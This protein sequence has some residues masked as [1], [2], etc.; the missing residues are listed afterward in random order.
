MLKNLTIFLIISMFLVSCAQKEDTQDAPENS[1]NTE[2]GNPFNPENP[3]SC[4]AL[5]TDGDG[6]LDCQDPDIDNDGFLNE[7]DAFPKDKY[8]WLDSDGD[9]VGDNTDW[10]PE[11]PREQADFDGDTIGDNYDDDDDNDGVPDQFESIGFKNDTEE[12]F[13][14]DRDTLGD[15]VHD[16]DID[17][18]G[19]PNVFDDLFWNKNG[20][21]DIDGDL[22]PNESD[23]DIDGDLVPNLQDVFPYDKTE[24]ADDDLDILG[25]NIDP[26]D[27]ND[28][29]P[30]SW[31]EFPS[32]KLAI[33][34]S[35]GDGY[36]NIE[37]AFPFN[38]NEWLDSDGDGVGDNSD[39]FPLNPLESKDTDGDGIGDNTDSDIDND[40]FVNCIPLDLSSSLDC[41]RD[42][43]PEDR[44][45][46]DDTDG[47]GIGDNADEDDD[48]DMVPDVFD[49]DSLDGT[50]FSDYDKDR[51]PDSLFPISPEEKLFLG[52][53]SNEVFFRLDADMDNDG[54]PNIFDDLN[55][56]AFEYFD[57]DG[58]NIGHK[59]DLD[60]DGDGVLD[61]LDRFKYDPLEWSDYDN[62]LIGDN[63]D[64]DDDNDGTPDFWDSLPKNNRGFSDINGDNVP[65][66]TSN[67]LDG[68]GRFNGSFSCSPSNGIWRRNFLDLDED[69][70]QDSFCE[71]NEEILTS[72]KI[73]NSNSSN[74]S[75]LDVATTF[76]EEQLCFSERDT[77]DKLYRSCIEDNVPPSAGC[78]DPNTF[79]INDVCVAS[80][81]T[82][83]ANIIL[84]AESSCNS[85]SVQKCKYEDYSTNGSTGRNDLYPWDSEEWQ[86]IDGD[87]LPDNLTDFDIDNDGVPD[88]W[89]DFPSDNVRD[90]K[91]RYFDIDGDSFA[92]M[93]YYYD[94]QDNI[95]K[96]EY[97]SL[98]RS[99][100]IVDS[101]SD[102]DFVDQGVLTC[103]RVSDGLIVGPSHNPLTLEDI[104]PVAPCQAGEIYNENTMSCEPDPTF[105]PIIVVDGSVDVINCF[106]QKEEGLDYF[107]FNENEDSD[108][109]SDRI[110]D[111]NDNDI[112]GDRQDNCFGGLYKTRF[113]SPSFAGSNLNQLIDLEDFVSKRVGNIVYRYEKKSC[114]DDDLPFVSRTNLFNDATFIPADAPVGFGEIDYCGFSDCYY[115]NYDRDNDGL[116]DYEE[117]V[118]GS[119]PELAD[120]DGDL[121][122]D[123]YER[124]EGTDPLDSNSFLDTDKDGIPN[125]IDPF[126]KG[127]FDKESLLDQLSKSSSCK[128]KESKELCEPVG[129][130]VPFCSWVDDESKL[131]VDESNPNE[132][133]FGKKCI[134]QEIL[135]TKDIVLDD[136]L[137]IS[138]QIKLSS[139]NGSKIIAKN[140]ENSV[141]CDSDNII[142]INAIENSELLLDNIIIETN[143]VDIVISS[144]GTSLELDKSSISSNN[145]DMTT[146]I[147][148]QNNE[149]LFRVNNSTLRSIM[150]EGIKPE[151][152]VQNSMINVL[153]KDM[154]IGSTLLDC[155]YNDHGLEEIVLNSSNYYLDNFICIQTS[156]EDTVFEKNI[157]TLM[158]LETDTGSVV[159]GAKAMVHN[160]IIQTN[161][162]DINTIKSG[163]Q[164]LFLIGSGFNIN[165]L[166]VYIKDRE[167]RFSGMNP[168]G[169][170][171]INASIIN[172][173][174]S[175]L[176]YT[177]IFSNDMEGVL[178]C[179]N[180]SSDIL[181]TYFSQMP[182]NPILV[183]MAVESFSD[184]PNNILGQNSYFTG[185]SV[186]N[187]F[188]NT[189]NPYFISPVAYDGDNNRVLLSSTS[190]LP[191]GLS[192]KITGLTI[193]NKYKIVTNLKSLSVAKT[194]IDMN[195]QLINSSNES[196][197][198]EIVNIIKEDSPQQEPLI[199][200]N[201]NLKYKYRTDFNNTDVV[202]VF[203]AKATELY[204]RINNN[205]N[206]ENVYINSIE[207]LESST[208]NAQILGAPLGVC[209]E[210][211]KHLYLKQ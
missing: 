100:Y 2:V 197:I 9:G 53:K 43:F 70:I 157:V 56:E 83:C 155:N 176:D 22:I 114:D 136:C 5:D 207:L 63:A 124:T 159:S 16:E 111:F 115:K 58:D 55:T 160:S 139:S 195:L 150:I 129:N 15:T 143:N 205:N 134:S 108:I 158:G 151:K 77:N 120:T 123:I 74:P 130:I 110:G 86:D 211:E 50:T 31:E 93:A 17:N 167:E 209:K 79:I 60:D 162:T 180:E 25:N 11:D 76:E 98:G 61:V 68:D 7:I 81:S 1:R 174:E 112:D 161:F 46:W 133:I 149:G 118:F 119:N 147:E 97:G 80:N 95:F 206:S 48:G 41:N 75:C 192:S 127:S 202:F 105:V 14:V 172:T 187:S 44:F 128:T 156:A 144:S 125:S 4:L 190:G 33:F 196:E 140:F 10:A 182:V 101:D 28:S 183:P 145:N 193:G 21:F 171:N 90:E 6:V 82:T 52:I 113:N 154:K 19:A 38:P 59:T 135:I 153:T 71:I 24:W 208:Y 32:N 73:N 35:D 20:L 96:Y 36:S 178:Y 69:D 116:T 27:D 65:D 49:Q 198:Y 146:I 87:T 72:I 189:D 163:M 200:D 64:E 102:N 29:F 179:K 89:D 42:K 210:D 194:D 12:F 78:I 186:V 204:L 45:E 57:I 62:D 203:R 51:I 141:R 40:G 169:V 103:I 137:N 191:E 132:F 201:I 188:W 85:Y 47:D 168:I 199:Y 84:Q 99:G 185:A 54:V 177:K 13:D 18:D 94:N 175:E 88:N 138:G 109:D 37:D 26:D 39:P 173:K 165:P 107:P 92:N 30:D 34:D 184:I 166:D 164:G 117:Y 106:Y 66:I 3:E 121:V 142:L 67:D 170:Y 122:L 104:R 181:P 8:E 23:F 148:Y 152:E 131:E 91:W 126:P